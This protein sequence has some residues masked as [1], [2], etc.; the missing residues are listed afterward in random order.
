MSIQKY[1]F[2]QSEVST[3]ITIDQWQWL[4]ESR[5]SC[6]LI[7]SSIAAGLSG[8][9]DASSGP[10]MGGIYLT[11]LTSLNSA[12]WCSNIQFR[13][14]KHNLACLLWFRW[15]NVY[16]WDILIVGERTM[17][18]FCRVILFIFSLAI[19][20]PMWTKTHCT[21]TLLHSGNSVMSLSSPSL[22]SVYTWIWTF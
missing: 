15:F 10:G 13:T 9:L 14:L 6:F 5:L 8:S 12:A 21:R 16:L 22:L 17:D 18:T 11:N 3:I 4:P 7:S 20:W 1:H 19:T 2:N